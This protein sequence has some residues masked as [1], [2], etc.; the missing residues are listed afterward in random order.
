[1]VNIQTIPT[2][3][4]DGQKPGTSGLR[5]RVKVFQEKNYTENFIQ[6]ILEAI[7]ESDGGAKGATLV[8]G[9][10]GRYYSNE[11]LQV[12]VKSSVAHSVS[13]LIVGRD[14]IVST[15]AVSNIIRQ[16]KATG[17]IVLTAS[18]NPGGPNSDFGIKYNCSNGGPAPESVTNR[19][20]EISKGIKELKLADVPKVD[21]SQLGTQTVGDL[22]IEVI[23][24]VDDY[25][26]L[27][28]SIFD[29]DA[30]KQFFAANKEFKMLFDGM[31]GVTGPYGYRL[32]VEEFGLP[33]SSV[34]RY[35]PLPDFGGAH[36][37]PNLTYAHDLVE[38]VEKQG[39]DFGA[40]SDG[41]GD[42]NMIIGKNAFVTP[43]DSV[44][45]IAHY[46]KEAIPYF[47]KNGVNGLARS[48]PTSQA[49]DLV[50][51]KMGVEHFE[52][53]TGWKFFGN[54]MDAGRC[55]VC[56][57]ESFGTGSDHIREK[58]GLWA[59]LA[60]LSIIAYVNKEKKAG[61]Q[62]ILQEHYKIYGRN[63]FSRY[64]Y[65]EVDGKGAENMVSHL[66]ELIEKKELINKTLGPFTVA[67]ADDFEY[68]DPIDGSVAKNQGIRII[69]K[70]GSRIVMRLSG[71]GSQGA[72]VRLYVEKYSNDNSEY[73]KD[74]QAAL[75]PLIDV[76]LELSQL[77]K[78]TG[79]KEPTVIT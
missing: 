57:E 26:A 2:K 18:H 64:D 78:Y 50:A 73:K 40:A 67:E 9:G 24:G 21:F 11:V 79:R 45:I 34:M 52:V 16:R 41:D 66:R 15:P 76:A 65:E 7:P 61:V 1:M 75:K 31:N 8:V 62:D 58:D 20:Y 47:K 48:M 44:A 77:E 54:L 6:S 51:K 3:P 49:V 25:V 23:D 32:F 14:G 63:F 55:S 4:F 5:K 56:G 60:W 17:G 33:E 43:S 42:R 74:T 70:D 27:M 38:A 39:L 12:I 13:K 30:I 35:K 59:I 36:P 28:K 72:T 53:P 10:D 19:I 69:F 37:D 22:T 46:A 68:L 29:F 71:T